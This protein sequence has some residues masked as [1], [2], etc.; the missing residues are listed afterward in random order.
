MKT[1]DVSLCSLCRSDKRRETEL[2][3]MPEKTCSICSE[4]GKGEKGG[5][6]THWKLSED[7][8]SSS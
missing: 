4:L 2:V 3:D 7:V 8:F 6:L 5:N 1:E